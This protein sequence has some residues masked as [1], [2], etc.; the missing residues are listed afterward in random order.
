[1]RYKE[2]ILKIKTKDAEKASAIVS[3]L[4]IGGIYTEDY[5]D[6]LDCPLVK[7]F[8]LVDEELLKKDKETALLHIYFAEHVNMEEN[9]IFIK[10]R[11]D[12]EQISFSVLENTVKEE[13]FQNNWKQYYKPL[14]IKN[15]TVVPE[16]EDYKRASGETILRIDPGVAFG[17]GNHETTALCLEKLQEV[18]SP[19]GLASQKNK[20]LKNPEQTEI[21]DNDF[22]N[23]EV[24]DITSDDGKETE[25]EKNN[26]QKDSDRN[27]DASLSE[28]LTDRLDHK[29]NIDIERKKTTRVL[30]LGCGSGILS[31]AALILGAERV[32]AVDIDPNAVKV[33]T[34]NVSLN[35]FQGKFRA[36]TGDILDRNGNFPSIILNEKYDIIIANIVADVLI[37]LCDFIGDYM[38]EKA[39]F[40][41]SGIITERREEVIQ[42]LKKNGFK[43]IEDAEKRGWRCIVSQKTQREKQ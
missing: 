15:I 31:I 19:E 38:T 16:W 33:A 13:D 29:D 24:A 8:A 36:E 18:L 30:D 6:L 3:M 9:L 34:R 7:N 14:K 4:D 43:V 39:Y 10:E 35:K 5:S 12:A 25:T 20:I 41:L 1:M 28:S 27:P 2:I 37:K 21:K 40:I 42:A 26:S 11:F 17:T 23:K 32:D 22:S